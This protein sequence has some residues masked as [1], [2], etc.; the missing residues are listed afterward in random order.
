VTDDVT[1]AGHSKILKRKNLT[2][3]LPGP[4]PQIKIQLCSKCQ[5]E[6]SVRDPTGVTDRF[7][8]L[9][10]KVFAVTSRDCALGFWRPNRGERKFSGA[11][12]S[13]VFG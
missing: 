3:R 7:V 10:A 9:H 12:C 6:K 13:S 1:P 11:N 4:R 5:R 2:V 8:K